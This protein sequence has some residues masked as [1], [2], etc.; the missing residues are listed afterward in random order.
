MGVD[1]VRCEIG[2]RYLQA[3]CGR[4]VALA[5]GPVTRG[6]I[7][8]EELLSLRDRRRRV[9]RGRRVEAGRK[10]LDREQCEARRDI[11]GEAE[12]Q[13]DDRPAEASQEDAPDDQ[14]AAGGR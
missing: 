14:E 9:A 13:G 8:G 1:M 7:L 11:A 3:P 6:A 5:A 2:R 10:R 12:A 4:S